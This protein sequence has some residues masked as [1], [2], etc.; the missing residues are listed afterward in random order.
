VVNRLGIGQKIIQDGDWS[1]EQPV[2]FK[3]YNVR[4]PSDV[5]WLTEAPVTIV[6]RCYKYHKL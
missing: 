1:I 5:C 4:P 6:I 2:F 3:K